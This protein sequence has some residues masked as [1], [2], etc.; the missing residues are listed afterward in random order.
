M[1]TGFCFDTRISVREDGDVGF[2]VFAQTPKG[3]RNRYGDDYTDYCLL[4][5]S[6]RLQLKIVS[7]GLVLEAKEGDDALI[8][9]RSIPDSLLVRGKECVQA[10][11]SSITRES[12]SRDLHSEIGCLDVTLNPWMAVQSTEDQIGG[13]TPR[14]LL[15]QSRRAAEPLRR[16]VESP[17]RPCGMMVMIPQMF[18]SVLTDFKSCN[19]EMVM[20]MTPLTRTAA[21]ER[22]QEA[23]IDGHPFLFQSS[24]GSFE[25]TGLDGRSETFQEEDL[26]LFSDIPVS[27]QIDDTE[28]IED[29]MKQMMPYLQSTL[30]NARECLDRWKSRSPSTATR[31]HISIVIE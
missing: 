22:M 9:L 13:N 25:V 14:E 30:M 15:L 23:M 11:R 12:I 2:T 29:W 6:G 10:W 17:E 20:E 8:V 3:S 4:F 19:G 24:D 5:P 28:Y 26:G 18:H 27:I 7:G 31:Y 1:D 16:F 21:K